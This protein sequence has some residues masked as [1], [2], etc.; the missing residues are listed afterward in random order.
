MTLGKIKGEQTFEQ[1]DTVGRLFSGMDI[2]V[3][4]RDEKGA[5][6]ELTFH[7]AFHTNDLRGKV[8]RVL[9]YLKSGKPM[10]AEFTK[11]QTA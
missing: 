7:Y 2:S 4:Y 1:T 9:A 8:E 6:R 3:E 10:P 5:K 11:V